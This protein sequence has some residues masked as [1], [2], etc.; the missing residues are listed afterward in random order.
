[1]SGNPSVLN[2]NFVQG[3]LLEDIAVIPKEDL[4]SYI[5]VIL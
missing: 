3:K 4:K 1:M 2:L 5:K